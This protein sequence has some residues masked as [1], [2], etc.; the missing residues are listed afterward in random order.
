[1]KKGMFKPRSSSDWSRWDSN[2]A[3]KLHKLPESPVSTHVSSALF[4]NLHPPCHPFAVKAFLE[5]FA[6]AEHFGLIT[7]QL[8][9]Q[10]QQKQTEKQVL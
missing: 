4:S 9:L 10:L 5:D 2:T 8:R 7:M 6:A 1:M 3:Q